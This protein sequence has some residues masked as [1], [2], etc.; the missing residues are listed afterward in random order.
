[1]KSCQDVDRCMTEYVDGELASSERR[2]VDAHLDACAPC[3]ERGRIERAARALLKERAATLTPPAPVALE[4]RCR[5]VAASPVAAASVAPA[6]RLG[7]R[8]RAPLSL[9]AA[10]VVIVAVTV[11]F[12]RFS[13]Q[14]GPVVAAEL[15]LDHTTCFALAGDVSEPAEL[16]SL[17]RSF[18]Q[19]YGW[20]AGIP[21]G[22]EAPGVELLEARRCAYHAGQ[23]AHVLCRLDGEPLS[24]YVLPQGVR[25]SAELS[26]VGQQVVIW[27]GDERTYALVGSQARPVL[28]RVAS[29]IQRGTVAVP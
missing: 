11:G 29:A 4:A 3:R 22:L 8:W 12:L 28:R 16:A 2:A 27:S 7:R 24:L 15:A 26:S 13:G 1:M 18:E 17:E 6:A 23:M 20:R 19:Q 25:R 14:A 5:A 9:A 21:A 10:A